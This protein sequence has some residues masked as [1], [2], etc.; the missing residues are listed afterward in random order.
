MKL[1]SVFLAG[2]LLVIL[3]AVSN[4]HHSVA[5]GYFLNQSKSVQGSV[6]EIILRNP[7]SLVSIETRDSDGRIRRWS[8]DWLSMSELTNAGV[9]ASTLKI[10]DT[11]QIT[12]APARPEGDHRLLMTELERPSDGW[13]WSGIISH[14]A[15][16]TV[17]V[18]R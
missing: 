18:T 3:A 10:G 12:G 4:A 16:P 2:A 8:A 5:S 11:V 14:Q 15:A 7:H 1:S 17:V 9:S 6:V 13:K